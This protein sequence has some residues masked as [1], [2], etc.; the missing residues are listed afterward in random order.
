M[1]QIIKKA[2]INNVQFNNTKNVTNN[3][4]K[5]KHKK[6]KNNIPIKFKDKK[7]RN[8]LIISRIE[9]NKL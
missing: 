6:P 3:E 9:T 5:L 2:Y 7:G 1:N 8:K 4:P